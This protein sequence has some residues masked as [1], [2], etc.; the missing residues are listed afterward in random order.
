MLALHEVI[1]RPL[2]T[3][4]SNSLVADNNQVCFEVRPQAS[5]TE[6]KKAVEKLFNV[7]VKSVNTSIVH[8]KVKTVGRNR[9]RLSNWKKAIVTLKEGQTLEFFDGV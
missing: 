2:L 9:G 8:G 7:E 4:K 5:K 6:I 3:E 1:K